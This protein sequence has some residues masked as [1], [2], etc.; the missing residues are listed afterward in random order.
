MGGE[1]GAE[2]GE[3]SGGRDPPETVPFSVF[4]LC[5]PPFFFFWGC[6]G[7]RRP[8]LA[9][10]RRMDLQKIVDGGGV[11]ARSGRL[12]LDYTMNQ[13]TR[14]S[15]RLFGSNSTAGISCTSGPRAGGWWGVR[16][17]KRQIREWLFGCQ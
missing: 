10:G 1:G 6:F 7:G 16:T 5:L 12:Y 15:A 17:A 3:K 4:S 9:A 11:Q 14:T 8:T 13:H 2:E